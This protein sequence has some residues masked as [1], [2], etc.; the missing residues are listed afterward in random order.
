MRQPNFKAIFDANC[1]DTN[2]VVGSLHTC[3]WRGLHEISP[4]GR[5][6]IGRVHKRS[7]EHG[8]C[9]CGV[10]RMLPQPTAS[11]EEACQRRAQAANP[12][13]PSVLIVHT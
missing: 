1:L 2:C 3:I 7:C 10:P 5:P 13:G 8:P 4:L 11:E 12:A 6:G 9:Q